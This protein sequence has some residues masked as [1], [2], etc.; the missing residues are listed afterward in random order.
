MPRTT[1]RQ[2]AIRDVTRNILLGEQWMAMEICDDD[3][4][5]DSHDNGSLRNLFTEG[6]VMDSDAGSLALFDDAAIASIL[7]EGELRALEE[8]RY[9]DRG[10][11]RK[12]EISVFDEHLDVDAPYFL[13]DRSFREHY[14]CSR[15]SLN[16][17]ASEI[18]DHPVFKNQRGPSQAPIKHQLMTLLHYMGHEG[19][20]NA[21]QGSALRTAPSPP[22]HSLLSVPRPGSPPRA[23]PTP[24][25]LPA[26]PLKTWLID[27]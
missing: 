6:G 16:F 10:T 20:T 17:I 2:R 14:R 18:E 24:F 5:T 13:N 23:F 27:T 4:T 9:F 11:F 12:S 3:T 15:D 26:V 21:S 19:M 8:H 1:E 7:M 25:S 22:L